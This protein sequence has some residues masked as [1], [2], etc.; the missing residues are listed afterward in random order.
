MSQPDRKGKS[1]KKEKVKRRKEARAQQRVARAIAGPS[2]T[3]AEA[4]RLAAASTA[5]AVEVLPPIS[6]RMTELAERAI[7]RG[8]AVRV[9]HIEHEDPTDAGTFLA[10]AAIQNKPLV[11]GCGGGG[12][13]RCPAKRILALATR[14]GNLHQMIDYMGLSDEAWWIVGKMAPIVSTL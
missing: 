14:C 3:M 4:M 10:L 11:C 13:G 9:D 7:A 5:V 1:G 8:D 12:G 2:M 6:H